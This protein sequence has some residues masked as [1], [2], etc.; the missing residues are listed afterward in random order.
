M[1]RDLLDYATKRAEADLQA[2]AAAAAPPE[3]ASSRGPAYAAEADGRDRH[4]AAEGR[5]AGPLVILHLDPEGERLESFLLRLR[6]MWWPAAAE[7]N[8]NPRS[9]AP[10]PRVSDKVDGVKEKVDGVKRGGDGQRQR[11]RGPGGR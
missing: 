11:G 4:G 3:Q 2:P 1:V 7:A 5:A 10:E 9:P 8:A 6:S